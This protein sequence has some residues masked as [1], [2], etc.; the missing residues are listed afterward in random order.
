MLQAK[1][2]TNALFTNKSSLPLQWKWL[3]VIMRPS[4]HKKR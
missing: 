4:W 1:L 2:F 3:K